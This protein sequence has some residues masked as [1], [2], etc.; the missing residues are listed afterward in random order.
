MNPGTQSGRGDCFAGRRRRWAAGLSLT[1]VALVGAAAALDESHRPGLFYEYVALPAQ[2]LWTLSTSEQEERKYVLE[3]AREVAQWNG[4]RKVGWPRVNPYNSNLG[5]LQTPEGSFTA[6]LDPEADVP[7][8]ARR[9]QP[10]VNDAEGAGVHL[11][12][13]LEGGDM[14]PV[15]VSPVEDD[16]LDEALRTARA[17]QALDGVQHVALWLGDPSPEERW[18]FAVPARLDV[19]IATPA[20]AGSLIDRARTGEV[21]LL[22]RAGDCDLALDS[23]QSPASLTNARRLF[24]QLCADQRLGR[25]TITVSN[26]DDLGQVLDE[27]RIS[28]STSTDPASAET[29]AADLWPL[30]RASGVARTDFLV[31]GVESEH[32]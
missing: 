8:L 19:M 27:P 28:V 18:S 20:S 12:V 3:Q 30:V 5:Q 6:T 29:T 10:L 11:T 32:A 7:A 23:P 21:Y 4:I 25:S 17:V 31:R 16:V 26:R 13:R 9:L 14:S 24:E 2:A 1:L 15:S 22:I